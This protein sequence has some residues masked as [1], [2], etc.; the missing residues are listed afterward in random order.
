MTAAL[1]QRLAR[2]EVLQF[3][4]AVTHRR[5]G[6][7]RHAFRYG[8]DYLL[9]A[10]ETSGSVALFGRNRA[11]LFTVHDRDHG[12]PRGA[13]RGASWAWDRLA[14]AG[15]PRAPDMVLGLMTQPRFLGYW[16]NPVSFWLLWQGDDLRAVIAEVN[17]T[18]GQR[19][20]Y[21]CARP[22][23]APIGAAEVMQVKKIFHVS[24]FQKVAGHYDFR[25]DL[26]VERATIQI[27]HVDGDDGLVAAM[28][29]G[30]R[31]A[32]AA[33]LVAAALRRP[34]G[35][36][37]VIAL[38]YWQALRLKLKGAVYRPVPP[39]PEQEISR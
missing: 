24:P 17:N 9:F 5:R 32:T 6:G 23:F 34:G 27:R 31:Q 35:A 18:F 28:T 11:N 30:L 15:L 1:P 10:P 4:A 33:R 22:G 13:G 20:S 2:G 19:H 29:G 12:G 8:A 16:F 21:L 39:A 25:F 26:G 3:S 7:L 37:R 38:I 36:L 14:E